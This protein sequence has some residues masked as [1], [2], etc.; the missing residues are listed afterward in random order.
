MNVYN[1]NAKLDAKGEATVELPAWFEALNRDV[2]YQLTPIGAFSPLYIKSGVK[3]NRFAIAG[4]SAGQE[5][6]WQVT[7]IR[8]DAYAEAHRIPV[9]VK[10]TGKEKGR[11]LHPKEHGKPEAKGIAKLHERTLPAR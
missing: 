5:V 6:S 7:G 11:Y 9:E 3:G 10:K 2:R 1:G 8:K 4:G